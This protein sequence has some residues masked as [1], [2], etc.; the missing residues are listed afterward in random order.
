[1]RRV[2]MPASLGVSP[3]AEVD[4]TEVARGYGVHRIP[5][6]THR[7]VVLS[8]RLW[9]AIGSRN[10]VTIPAGRDSVELEYT[11][12][13]VRGMRGQLGAPGTT[14]AAGSTVTIVVLVAVVV[15]AIAILALTLG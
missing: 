1:M 9:G 10:S 11:V 3:R 2:G 15:V 13:A 6:P 8:C 4:G 5:L 14:T 12:P 7:S